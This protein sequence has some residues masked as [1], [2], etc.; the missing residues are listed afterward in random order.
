MT[1]LRRCRRALALL[2]LLSC[3]AAGAAGGARLL[4]VDLHVNEQ[5]MGDAF[6]VVDDAG[7]FYIDEAALSYWEIAR[8]W[9][10]PL[11]FRGARYYGVHE[12]HGAT[13]TFEPQRMELRLFM[14]AGLMP[15]RRVAMA[16]RGIDAVAS[17]YGMFMDYDVNWLQAGSSSTSSAGRLAI[18]LSST[19]KKSWNLFCKR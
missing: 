9:P 10:E 12:F 2:L 5:S 6:V 19:G 3:A 11:M 15:T 7:N 4:I 17:G 18:R 16:G 1:C 8:P 14:P 13:I